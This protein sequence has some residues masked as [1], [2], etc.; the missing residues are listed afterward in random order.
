MDRRS[1]T[2]FAGATTLLGG[3]VRD[4][5][6]QAWRLLRYERVSALKFALP[7]LIGIYILSPVDP[8]P[9]FILGLGQIDD[10]G[11]ATAGVLLLARLIPGL[12]PGSVV[13]EHVRDMG[14]GG[15]AAK[16][17][18]GETRDAVEARFRVRS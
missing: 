8:I 18:G 10:L 5:L 14:M 11:V 3:G 16:P 6:R 13:D 2:A 12:A 15:V 9:D 7:V 4:Q 1:T 17:A